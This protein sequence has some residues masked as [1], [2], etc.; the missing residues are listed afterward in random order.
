MNGNSKFGTMTV[1]EASVIQTAWDQRIT[2]VAI[3]E[4]VRRR[5]ARLTGLEITDSIGI[6]LKARQS[7]LTGSIAEKWSRKFEQR[8]K[9]KLRA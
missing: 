6:L 4:V 5:V 3:D 8:Y 2:L 1:G 9:W 7:G